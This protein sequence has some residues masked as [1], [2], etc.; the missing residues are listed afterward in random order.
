MT[1]R[2]LPDPRVLR[3]ALGGLSCIVTGAGTGI[4]RA[5]AMRLAC[6]GALVIGIGRRP[7]PL[8]ETGRMIAQQGG[9]YLSEPCDIRDAD[10][11]AALLHRVGTSHGIDGLVN[12]AGGQFASP[13]EEI[14]RNGWNAVIDLNLSAVF[15]LLKAA[16]PF[17]SRRG[18]SVVNI[19]LSLVERGQ[20]GVAHSVAARAGVLGLTRTLALEWANH[21]IRLNCIGPGTVRTE[22]LTTNYATEAVGRLTDAIPLGRDTMVEE[23]AELAAFLIS[24][25]GSMMTGQLIQIDGGAHLGPGIDMLK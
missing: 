12:N 21:G 9:R 1:E 15:T 6:L 5:I 17:L 10:A 23:V 25:A 13:A 24:P 19:S 7:E 2:A 22:S 18:G 4:G 3:H 14:S 11:I 20:V 16:Y 8:A